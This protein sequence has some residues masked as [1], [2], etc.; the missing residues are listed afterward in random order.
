MQK[1]SEKPKSPKIH[2][3]LASCPELIAQFDALWVAMPHEYKLTA[4]SMYGLDI[5]VNLSCDVK[6]KLLEC[7]ASWL[8]M[9][10]ENQEQQKRKQAE[11][12]FIAQARTVLK[13]ARKHLKDL[14]HG[15][16]TG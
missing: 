1:Q 16:S 12:G 3:A 5:F 6:F 15:K 4:V 7:G 9:E 10:L 2:E 8:E 11:L 13:R 14:K